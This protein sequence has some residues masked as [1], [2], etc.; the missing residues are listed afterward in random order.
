MDLGRGYVPRA[1]AG[2]PRDRG[3]GAAGAQDWLKKPLSAILALSSAV[4]STCSGE[5]RKTL[6]VT[7][8]ML[9]E[10]VWNYH[11]DPQTNV[12]DQ[13]LS[14]LRQKLAAVSEVPLIHTV[15]GAGYM[16]RPGE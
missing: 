15:R 1:P 6:L 11:F 3:A 12:I 9:L 14:R 2:A 5:S 10:H 16:L 7:R 8:S 13:H 4:T